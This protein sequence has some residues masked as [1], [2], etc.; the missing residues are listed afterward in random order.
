MLKEFKSTDETLVDAIIHGFDLV[1]AVGRK[2]L[3]PA[4][5]QPAGLIVE[6]LEKH[7][8]KRTKAIMNSGKS[9]ADLWA[10]SWLEELDAV[11]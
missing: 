6:D 5:F 11:P 1:G 7:A 2:G 4:D 3:L 10:K 8:S 9:S